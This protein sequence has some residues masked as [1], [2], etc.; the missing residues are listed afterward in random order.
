MSPG[1]SLSL[2]HTGSWRGAGAANPGAPH[3]RQCIGFQ[4]HDD[5]IDLAN[6]LRTRHR[7]DRLEAHV[8]V[9]GLDRQ[10][11]LLQ[12]RKLRSRQES[13]IMACLEQ[14]RAVVQPDCAGPDHGNLLAAG[15]RRAAHCREAWHTPPSWCPGCGAAAG[16]GAGGVAKTGSR[17]VPLH[18]DDEHRHA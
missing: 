5:P 13:D 11:T 6:V 9:H 3:R 14:P 16:P 4:R 12:H 7:L 2:S 15:P 8:A 10:P 18:A 1:R 17:L